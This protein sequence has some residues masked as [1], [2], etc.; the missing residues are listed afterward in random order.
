MFFPDTDMLNMVLKQW[1]EVVRAYSRSS[2]DAEFFVPVVRTVACEVGGIP[3][4]AGKSTASLAACLAT[5]SKR[6]N[7]ARQWA[8]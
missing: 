1:R 5:R 7:T 4:L 3:L 6:E 2:T 8:T